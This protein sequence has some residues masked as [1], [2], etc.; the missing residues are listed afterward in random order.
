[1][2]K[3]YTKWKS[4]NGSGFSKWPQLG[5][6]ISDLFGEI[7]EEASKNEYTLKVFLTKH[8]LKEE[9]AQFNLQSQ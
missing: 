9:Q 5:L 4:D 6:H 8:G 2:K 7:C 1:M 3:E